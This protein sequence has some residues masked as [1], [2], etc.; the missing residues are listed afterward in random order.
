[1][2]RKL[3]SLIL[4]LLLCMSVV[5]CA[6]ATT[7][8]ENETGVLYDEADLLTVAEENALRTKLREIGGAFNAQI[9]VA[10]VL[11]VEGDVSD[12]TEYVYD[13]MGFGFGQTKDGVLLLVSMD[14]RE[15]RILSNGAAADAISMSAIERIGDAIAPDLSDG[16]YADAFGEFAD[17][18]VYYLDGYVNGFPFNAG[19]NL[20]IALIVGLLVGLIVS[21]VLKA[22]LKS[23]RKQERADVYV[24]QGS[25]ELTTRLDLFLYRDVR[26]TRKASSSSS[27]SGGSSRNVGGRSF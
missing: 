13:N 18:C 2:S 17:Q 27:S 7:S 20:V 26:K 9:V 4:A 15:L 24:K 22:Q 23:V 11:S 21:Y 5:L 3:I 8:A 16:N 14:P 12:Y 19:K 6:S 25:M 10:T 1:M